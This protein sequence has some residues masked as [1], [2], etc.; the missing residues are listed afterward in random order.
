MSNSFEARVLIIE[1]LNRYALGYD[2]GD[3][4]LLRQAFSSDAVSGG[5]VVGTYISWGPMVGREQIVQGLREMRLGQSI[6]PRH[7]IGNVLFSSIQADR[8]SLTCYLQLVAAAQG[9]AALATVGVLEVNA[10]VEDGNWYISH[11]DVNLDAPF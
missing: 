11:L 10:K 5:R 1:A 7:C 6:Q 8:A 9:S 2:Q 4:E 3:F